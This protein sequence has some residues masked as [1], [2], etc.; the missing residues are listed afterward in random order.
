MYTIITITAHNKCASFSNKKQASRENTGGAP[1]TSN[2]TPLSP[3]TRS[4]TVH[5]PRAPLR[6][7]IT[8]TLFTRFNSI[9]ILHKSIGKCYTQQLK[10]PSNEYTRGHA[11]S[12][13]ARREGVRSE[14]MRTQMYKWSTM[15]H[16]PLASPLVRTSLRPRAKNHVWPSEHEALL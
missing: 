6:C 5:V 11:K 14:S 12:T 9:G 8:Y 2:T 4:D 3:I 10:M 13:Y 7:I 15:A 16:G 1:R